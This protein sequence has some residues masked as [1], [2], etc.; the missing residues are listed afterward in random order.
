[1]SY[2][3]LQNREVTC[4]KNHSCE[5]CAQPIKAGEKAQYRAYV[6]DGEFTT[7]WQHPECYEAMCDHPH[8]WELAEGWT[9][10]DYRR[11][12]HGY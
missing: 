9:P 3:E 4:R 11:G 7:G 10:G 2:D 1:M 6:F 5:W 8:Q 12:M